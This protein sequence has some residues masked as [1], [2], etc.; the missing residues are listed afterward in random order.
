MNFTME[1]NPTFETKAIL[2]SEAMVKLLFGRWGG[3]F[4]DD[5]DFD[6]E[7][8]LTEMEFPTGPDAKKAKRAS[9]EAGNVIVSRSIVTV[10]DSTAGACRILL[11]HRDKHLVTTG[12]SILTSGNPH[13]SPS[14]VLSNKVQISTPPQEF[15]KIGI[16]LSSPEQTGD[17]HYL[18]EIF[19]TRIQ[20][21]AQITALKDQATLVTIDQAKAAIAGKRLE[22]E[23]LARIAQSAA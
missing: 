1:S 15:Q 14:D 10:T 11:M 13:A 6:L 20:D 22:E 4:F 8:L 18:F 12:G 19:R 16:G 23:V 7:S 9:A 3:S 2:T 17:I 5:E 21:D